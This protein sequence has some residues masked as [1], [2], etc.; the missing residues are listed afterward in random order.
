[1]I[2]LDAGQSFRELAFVMIVNIR[3]I[4]HARAFAVFSF[5]S[6]LQMG[7]QD[8]AN[9]LAA[10]GV[11]AFFDELIE[12]RGQVLTQRNSKT[13]HK[14]FG[15]LSIVAALI[16]TSG[17]P[18]LRF[19]RIVMAMGVIFLLMLRVNML[20][21]AVFSGMI[22]AVS[23]RLRAVRMIVRMFMAMVV[24]MFMPVRMAVGFCSMR[25]GMFMLVRVFVLMRMTVRMR[26]LFDFGEFH[27]E[28]SE[29]VQR[30]GGSGRHCPS[31]DQETQRPQRLY[32]C[33][34]CTAYS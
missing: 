20:V 6:R 21:F 14:V 33:T 10:A 8:V 18:Y 12:R 27:D 7:A 9:R 23:C 29:C 11:T 31:I 3:Q 22:V 34:S 4:C 32:A 15:Q 28:A 17:Q 1:M 2:V 26:V 19:C 5:I 25:V 16:L 24:Y 13:I 30:A